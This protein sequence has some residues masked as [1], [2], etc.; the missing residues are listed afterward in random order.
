LYGSFG[1]G[2]KSLENNRP[3]LDRRGSDTS[4]I[5]SISGVD[6]RLVQRID[7]GYESLSGASFG[8]NLSVLCHLIY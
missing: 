5:K 3:D 4:T 1:N 7:E 6:A 8:S 2:L